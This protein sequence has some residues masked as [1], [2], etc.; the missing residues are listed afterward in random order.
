MIH[1]GIIFSRDGLFSSKWKLIFIFSGS[2]KLIL[3]D[4]QEK[5][6]EKE[7]KISSTFFFDIFFLTIKWTDDFI[8]QKMI[9]PL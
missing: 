2:K 5:K 4:N 6:C 9:I 1:Q 7:T 8:D 3:M